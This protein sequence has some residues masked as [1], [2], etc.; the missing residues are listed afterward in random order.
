VDLINEMEFCERSAYIQTDHTF[1]HF[2][3]LLWDSEL[4]DRTTRQERAYPPA[5]EDEALLQKADQ[6]WRKLVETAP[7]I[8]RDERF[9]RELDRIVEAARRE[10][11]M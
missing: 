11:L 6:A 10:L 3:D 2:R 9:L 8:E 4:L 7:P 1:R 5:R